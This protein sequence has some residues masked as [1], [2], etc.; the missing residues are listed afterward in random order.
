LRY[1]IPYLVYIFGFGVI[2]FLYTFYIVGANLDQLGKVF[3]LIPLGLVVYNTFAF[4]FLSAIASTVIG[5]FLAMAV[6]LMS[7]GKRVVSL[8]SMLPYTIP[9]TSSALIWAISLYGHYGWFTYLLGIGYDPLYYKST[10]LCTL[11]LVNVWTSVPLSFLIMLSAIRSL[12]Q[13]IKE[14]SLVDGIPLSEYYSKV[15]FPAV[16]K[17][18]WLSFVLQFVISLGNFD[19]PYVLTQGGPGYSTTTLPLLVYDEMFELGNF[20]GGAVASAILGVFATIPSVI[21]LLL[22]RTKRNKLLPSFKLRV[23]DRAFKGLIYAL[24]ALLLFFLDFPVYWMFLVAFRKAYL[25]FSYPPILFPKDL[26]SSYF[27]T[28][29]G[30]SAPYMVTSVVVASTASLLTVLLSLPSAYEVSKGKGSWIL[31]LSI[32]L[33]SLPSASFVL[34]LFMFFSSVNL[35]NTWWALILSTPIFTATFGVWVLYNFFVDFPRAYDDAAEVFSIKRKLTRIIFPLSRPAMFSVLLLSFIFNW[36]LLFYPLVFS[37]TPYNYSFPPQGAQTVTLFALEALGNESLNWGLLASSALVAA[38]P[39]MILTLF[40]VDRV[41][42]GSY[43][44]GIKF[45]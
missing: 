11:V 30:S 19:L 27:L 12:P 31:P 21:L 9:F 45:V 42:K 5:S 22:I 29:L 17:A 7:R 34:P 43:K 28:A 33:Y 36:H 26:T 10:A 1:S 35:L 8:L 6:D 13:E 2:P 24:T 3:V 40:A 4:S 15:V 23:P 39:V 44:G 14:A 38:F 37:S 18:F 20:S 41:I 16:G 32:Y 25:D